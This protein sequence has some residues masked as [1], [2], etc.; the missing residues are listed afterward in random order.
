MLAVDANLASRAW[1]KPYLST[2]IAVAVVCAALSSAQFETY[3]FGRGNFWR[4][5][6][7]HYHGW[8]FTCH[9]HFV[10]ESTTVSPQSKQ[11]VNSTSHEHH[12]D[13]AKLI[14]N[15]MA[16]L[17]L[18]GSTAFV[19]EHIRR[20][21]RQR[22]QFGLRTLLVCMTIAAFLLVLYQNQ[23]AIL[24]WWGGATDNVMIVFSGSLLGLPW[25]VALPMAF[26]FGC[27]TYTLGWIVVR[28]MLGLMREFKVVFARQ[29][30]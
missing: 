4:F 27:A 13:A 25:Y 19:A 29:I 22:W 9:C 17:L 5:T 12:W 11:Y 23:T 20:N 16:W 18:I 15:I 26:S 14:Q 1:Y 6:T 21:C 3:G 10:T 28:T 8:P 7:S 2:L 24:L 30:P